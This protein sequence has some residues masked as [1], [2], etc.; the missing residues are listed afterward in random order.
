MRS[1]GF[2]GTIILLLTFVS[3]LIIRVSGIDRNFGLLGDQIRDWSIALRPLNELPFVGPPTHFGGYTIGPAFYWILWAIRVT[4]G[5]WF[6]NL[7]HAGGIGQAMLQSGVDT[8]LLVAVWKRTQSIWIALTTIVLLATAAY[9]LSLAAVIWNPVVGSTLAKLAIALVLLDWPRRS[10]AA[11]AVTAAAAWS[12]VHAYTGAIFVALG[13]FVALLID[14]F[15]RGDG[16]HRWHSPLGLSARNGLVI[17]VVMVL[18]QLPYAAHQASIR[19]SNSAMGVVTG[20]LGQI[21]SGTERPQFARSLASYVRA[22]N[23]IQVAPFQA[24]WAIWLLMAGVVIFAITYRR[25]PTLLTVTLLP[26][27]AALLGY[28]F[29]LGDL[30][31]YYYLSLMPGVV[32]AIVLSA[33]ALPGVAWRPLA[34]MVGVALFVGSLA[35]VPA[36]IRYAAPLHKMPEYG[37]LVDGSRKMARRASPMRAIETEF[38]LPVTADADYVYQVLGGR[39]DPESSWIGVIKSDGSVSYQRVSGPRAPANPSDI[40]PVKP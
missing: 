19:F 15:A 24:P 39:I 18:L 13:V 29:F 25:D 40:G 11:V 27:V 5:P 32:L 26:Q 37:A 8:I 14:P 9:D 38:T 17:A 4:V 3:T 34:R 21:L 2:F 22:F 10:A 28:A 1:F 30:D 36:R 20:S 23:G 12:A 35:L 6:D 33:T 16:R 7:P 31:N